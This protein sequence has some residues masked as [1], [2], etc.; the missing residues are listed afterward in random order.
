MLV[1]AIAVFSGHAAAAE[2][3]SDTVYFY[4][5]WQQMLDFDAEAYLVNPVYYN[6]NPYEI[7]FETGDDRINN[8]IE[9]KYIAFSQGD[10][11]WLINGQY[12]KDNF[13]GDTKHIDG[14]APVY[15]NDKTAFVVSTGPLGVKDILFGTDRDGVTS[16]TY[17]Y[18]YIDFVN[19]RVNRVTHEFLSGLLEEFHD[20]QM[21]YEGMKDYKKQEIIEE[22]FFKYI[23]RASQDFMH[24]YIVD[25]TK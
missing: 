25:L 14:F 7:Y 4:T 17:S 5:S 24:P 6:V 19:K 20:L 10:S 12:L 8:M 1:A 2:A 22:Y 23:D 18:Y 11:I 13:K 16:Y 9:E 21:R 3:T 15:F